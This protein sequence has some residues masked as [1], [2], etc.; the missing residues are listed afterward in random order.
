VARI[1]P[2]SQEP[3]G[4]LGISDLTEQ[5]LQGITCRIHRPVQVHPLPFDFDVGLIYS[6][7]VV[8]LF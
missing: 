6:P 5:E 3:F 7:G 8:G 4:S 2:P 1:K